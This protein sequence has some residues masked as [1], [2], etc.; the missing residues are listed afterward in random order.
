M[1][2][3]SV[4]FVYPSREEISRESFDVSR[5]ILKYLHRT[6]MQ[7]FSAWTYLYPCAHEC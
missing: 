3:A 4:L 2:V 6:H 1:C 7:Y 5:L